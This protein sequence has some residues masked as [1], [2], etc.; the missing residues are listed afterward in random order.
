MGSIVLLLVLC[1][2][3]PQDMHAFT[4]LKITNYVI[5]MCNNMEIYSIK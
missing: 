5:E 2:N 1:P 4:P 3:K